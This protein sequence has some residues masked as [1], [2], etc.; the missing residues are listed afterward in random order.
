LLIRVN[1]YQSQGL[2]LQSS[3]LLESKFPQ[4][5]YDGEEVGKNYYQHQG[6]NVGDRRVYK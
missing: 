5:F 2:K 4:T 1:T 3:D 6:P